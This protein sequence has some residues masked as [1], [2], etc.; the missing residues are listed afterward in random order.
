MQASAKVRKRIREASYPL[1]PK[2]FEECQAWHVEKLRRLSAGP[3]GSLRMA[4]CGAIIERGILAHTSFSGCDGPRYALKGTVEAYKETTSSDVNFHCVSAC[5][6]GEAQLKFLCNL[7]MAADAKTT[8]VHKDVESGIDPFCKQVLNRLQPKSDAS[9]QKKRDAYAAMH[10]YLISNAEIAYPI[11]GRFDCLVHK[12][13]CFAA[14]REALRQSI[15]AGAASGEEWYNVPD[16]QTKHADSISIH[17]GSTMCA[18]LSCLRSD[19]EITADA[20]ASERSHAVFIATRLARAKQRQEDFFFHENKLRYDVQNR[21][22]AWADTHEI[23]TVTTDPKVEGYEVSRARRL[24]C[25][26]A[27]HGHVYVGPENKQMAYDDIFRSRSVLD[28]SVYLTASKAQL[29]DAYKKMAAKHGCYFEGSER[30]PVKIYREGGIWGL[31]KSR[32]LAW[33]RASKKRWF[34]ADIGQNCRHTNK[35]PSHIPCLIPNSIIWSELRGGPLLPYEHLQAQGFHVEH[36][37]FWP[38]YTKVLSECTPHAMK[39]FA[40]GTVHC[41]VYAGFIMFIMGHVVAREKPVVQQ[42]IITNDFT[43]SNGEE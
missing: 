3:S 39:R 31:Q 43:D 38:E 35:P 10:T 19:A 6:L 8:C 18:G 41:G 32:L 42:H 7:S 33:K 29:V 30:D 22:E 17:L 26:I 20:H 2:S 28:G 9:V 15:E 11:D 5:D 25:G 16:M 12:K 34:Y 13:R 40:G 21:M 4:R 37:P 36:P 14:P 24:T 27:K 23:I 1:G